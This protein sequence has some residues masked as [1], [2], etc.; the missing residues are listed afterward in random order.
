MES[1][2]NTK[3]LFF[4]TCSVLA[5]MLNCKGETRGDAKSTS[6]S[7]L[8][9]RGRQKVPTLP[10][11]NEVV[12]FVDKTSS[13]QNV[14]S[15]EMTQGIEYLFERTKDKIASEGGRVSIYFIHKSLG[16]SPPFYEESFPLPDTKEMTKFRAKRSME[17]FQKR[18]DSLLR[19]QIEEAV[20]IPVKKDVGVDTDL[21]VSI[22]KANDRFLRENL[23]GENLILY[24]S[25][26]IESV[27]DSKCGRNYEKIYFKT[28]PEA[29][30]SGKNDAI[31]IKECFGVDNLPEGTMVYLFIPNGS[32]DLNRH[33]HIP[34]YWRAL[35]GEFGVQTVNSNL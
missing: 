31:P 1:S 23:S 12:I 10:V 13:L 11:K 4:L 26:M 8:N 2:R 34:D 14:S 6:P 15:G 17:S 18:L 27:K 3:L 28:V 33:R 30:Q 7:P 29:I 5:I 24:Y 9:E 22:K 21:F 32:L 25:D 16:S 19:L 20:K 35:F